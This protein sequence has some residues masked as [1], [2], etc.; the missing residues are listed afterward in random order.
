MIKL[1]TMGLNP[2]TELVQ[3]I[4][5][6]RPLPAM[7][8]RPRRAGGVAKGGVDSVSKRWLLAIPLAIY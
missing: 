7:T 4:F 8:G 6:P 3:F 1:S 5:N 2:A